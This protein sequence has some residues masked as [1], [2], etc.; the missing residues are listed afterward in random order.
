MFFPFGQ[1]SMLT[2]NSIYEQYTSK[3]CLQYT[4]ECLLSC[5]VINVLCSSRIKFDA[6]HSGSNVI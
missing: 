6:Q 2:L 4:I 1:C 3:H 5:L